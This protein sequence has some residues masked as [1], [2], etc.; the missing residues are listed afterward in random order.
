ALIM[1]AA[2]VPVPAHRFLAFALPVPLLVAIGAL[3][4]PAWFAQGSRWRRVGGAAAAVAILA[5]AAVLSQAYW[6]RSRPQMNPVLARQA[7]NAAAYLDR[8]GVP[9]DRAVVFVANL[10]RNAGR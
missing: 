3:A 6:L 2:G 10:G 8:A 1:A 4:L 9:E 5:G 7:E